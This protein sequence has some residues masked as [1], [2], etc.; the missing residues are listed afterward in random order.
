MTSER[1]RGGGANVSI[2]ARHPADGN[3]GAD[4][5]AVRDVSIP[6]AVE[7][8]RGQ[9]KETW[10][11]HHGGIVFAKGYRAR[12]KFHRTARKMPTVGIKTKLKEKKRCN[13][14]LTLCV[15]F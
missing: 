10:E 6:A 12:L 2:L 15:S 14:A 13:S 9:K 7:S 3:L 4:G 8:L 11:R 1:S 5:P